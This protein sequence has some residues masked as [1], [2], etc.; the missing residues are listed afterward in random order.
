VCGEI[1]SFSAICLSVLPSAARRATVA[2]V[3]VH[4]EKAILAGGCFWGLQDLIRKRPG[5]LSTRVGYTGA[6]WPTPRAADARR[7][8]VS[9]P[10]RPV[11]RFAF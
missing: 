1:N 7:V 6:T 9:A 2:S 5:V 3:S 11:S 4:T 10:H 8:G